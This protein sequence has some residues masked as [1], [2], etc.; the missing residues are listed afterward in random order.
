LP[1]AAKAK[2]AGLGPFAV[3]YLRMDGLTL[4]ILKGVAAE[5]ATDGKS[6]D[7]YVGL[8]EGA[9]VC[10]VLASHEIVPPDIK[11]RYYK[12]T[13]DG[14]MTHAAAMAG[15]LDDDGKPAKG[16][17]RISP[18]DENDTDVVT[19]FHHEMDFWTKGKYRKAPAAPAAQAGS[20]GA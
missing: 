18:L 19:Q 16:S 17:G 4:K 15:F 12:A 20:K 3:R 7:L 11:G 9:A 5:N 1:L 10:F 6:H 13:L 14:R 2:T 8:Q